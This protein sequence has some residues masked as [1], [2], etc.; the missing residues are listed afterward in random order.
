M[1]HSG[2]FLAHRQACNARKIRSPKKYCDLRIP[3]FEGTF[4]SNL[5]MICIG[6]L[7]LIPFI[8]P[9]CAIVLGSSKGIKDGE[10]RE[11]K[12]KLIKM[13]IILRIGIAQEMHCFRQRP[14][15]TH[16]FTRVWGSARIESVY[17]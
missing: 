10:I 8:R 16:E 6:H 12:V 3:A 7:A 14:G 9:E 2:H 13:G 11:F 4:F 5:S 17:F 1:A 15:Q